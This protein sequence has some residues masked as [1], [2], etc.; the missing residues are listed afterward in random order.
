[1]A[2]SLNLEDLGKI[3]VAVIY[4]SYDSLNFPPEEVVRL[5]DYCQGLKR[6][7][8]IGCDASTNHKLSGQL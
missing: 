1:M 3:I 7:L 5:T 6:L 2:V 8:L 4:L